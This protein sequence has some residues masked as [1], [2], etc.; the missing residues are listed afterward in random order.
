VG[1]DVRVVVEFYE[2][3]APAITNVSSVLGT[4]RP[5]PFTITCEITDIDAN[6]PSQAGIASATL[7]YSTDGGTTFDDVA[8]T[9]TGD[10]Y[11][12]ELPAVFTPG[13]TYY[14]YIS[15]TDKAGSTANSEQKSFNIFQWDGKT[16]ILIIDEGT[17][18]NDY[19]E[20]C[21]DLGY[22]YNYWN[23]LTRGTFDES[24][25]NAGFGTIIYYAQNTELFPTRDATGNMFKNFL[26]SGGNLYIEYWDYFFDNYEPSTPTFSAG[27][28]AYD[29]F[30]I[31]AGGNDVSYDTTIIGVTGDAITDQFANDPFT[32]GFFLKDYGYFPDYYWPDEVTAR[33]EAQIIF[34]YSTGPGAG[35]R[36]DSGT[37]KTV[38]MAT[39]LAWDRDIDTGS[40]SAKFVT[41]IDNVLQW[42]GTS[43]DVDENDIAQIPEAY[44]LG[45]NY[46]NPFNPT[47]KID[48]SIIGN[49]NVEITVFNM[50]GQ[51]IATLTNN[52]YQAGQYSVTWDASEMSAGIYFYRITTG[53]FNKTKKMILMH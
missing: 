38:Y 33:P 52:Y 50:L 25:P 27:D 8:M 28:M 43:T 47:T 1:F 4:A 9:A 14:Y 16:D 46:P 37:F 23:V 49:G 17:N 51:K 3:T 44:D 41:F 45:Q 53:D 24:I 39:E 18:W 11:S 31:A 2:N 5:G 20:I 21:D 29:Y 19:D 22:M 42:F 10:T 6:E 7:K 40:P 12:G 32:L 15:A 35:L 36:Y 34:N 13:V 48:F 30:G 26:D